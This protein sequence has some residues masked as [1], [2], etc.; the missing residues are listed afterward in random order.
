MSHIDN[1]HWSPGSG[2]AG[3][4]EGPGGH[5]AE[6]PAGSVVTRPDGDPS[7]GDWSP[8]PDSDAADSDAAEQQNPAVEHLREPWWSP[9]GM[10]R[11]M[12]SGLVSLVF[13]LVLLICLALIVISPPEESGL[14]EL[15]VE[16]DY[17]PEDEL[18]TVLLDPSTD[19][20][21]S[22]DALS[23]D[24]TDSAG[25]VEGGSVS[26]SEPVLSSP[27]TSEAP[28]EH[29]VSLDRSLARFPGRSEALSHLPDGM[30]GQRRAVVDGYGTALD[31]ITREILWMLDRSEVLVAWVFDESESMK[32]DQAEIRDR[33][34]RVYEELGLVG[35]TQGDALM[36]AVVSY[37]GGYNVHTPKPT[38]DLDRIREAI[39]RIPID[40]SGK[41]LMC[42]AVGQTIAQ[43]RGFVKRGGRRLALILVTDESGEPED[44]L[45]YLEATIEQARKTNTRIFVLGR[46]S[47]FGYPYAYFRWVHP[48]TMRVH[49]LPVNRGPETAFVEALQ[50]DGFR[51]R[52]D[53]FASGFGPYEQSRMAHQTGGIFFMLPSPESNL[54]RDEANRNFELDAMRGYHP[55]LRARHEVMADRDASA[56]R[57]AI[58]KV[59]Y[60]LNP[61]RPEVAE[62]IELRRHFSRDFPTFLKQVAEQKR[63]L[64]VYLNYLDQADK[65]LQSGRMKRLRADEPSLRWRANYDLIIAQLMAYKVRAYE[66][67]AYLD[68]FAKDPEVVPQRKPPNLTLRHWRIATRKELLTEEITG[69]YLERANELFA[70]CAENHPGTPWAARAEREMRA[71]YGVT[72]EPV[73]R[74]ETKHGGG[75]GGGPKIPIPKL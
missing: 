52:R 31:R 30:L 39:D 67:G 35:A 68:Q 66:Y 64:P 41:E 58:W 16:A 33:V 73:Y 29:V 46:E 8:A 19:P 49:W 23:F 40:D 14:A 69:E 36:T 53:A 51:R 43:Y 48:Q 65:A 55:D 42:R 26:V 13:H 60:D 25:A 59:I 27:R 20:V 2:H 5:T 54:A 72:L 37:G 75:G 32:D 45:A 62:T 1:Q 63:R 70:E 9:D 24:V 7:G 22:L 34:H 28:S 61:Y 21:E 6:C 17:E 56:L 12:T 44:N 50:I 3:A 47:V 74:P 38:S 71:G 11:G 4:M 18:Q 57:A 10:M 15:L